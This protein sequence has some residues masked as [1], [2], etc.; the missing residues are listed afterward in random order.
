LTLK[1]CFTFVFGHLPLLSSERAIRDSG[2]LCRRKEFR[3]ITLPLPFPCAVLH[4]GQ[5]AVSSFLRVA[6]DR[7]APSKS[8]QRKVRTPPGSMPRKTRGRSGLKSGAK[9]SV[10]ENQ[11]AGRFL[12][13]RVKRRGKS[14]PPGE[15]SPG[16]E[17]PHAVQDKTGSQRCLA[18][19]PQGGQLPGNSRISVRSRTRRPPLAGERNDH[20][21][22]P[23]GGP[24]RIRLIATRV[25]FPPALRKER[26]LFRASQV[27]DIADVRNVRQNDAC[28]LQGTSQR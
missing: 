10:T 23:Q 3:R 18:R 8:A 1:H 2:V 21:G 16:H 20:H 26:R 9:E 7:W 13:V 4:F 14:P 19:L 24:H 6:D 5:R 12:P 25:S 17:K 22:L 11:T 27:E 28:N 15:Q